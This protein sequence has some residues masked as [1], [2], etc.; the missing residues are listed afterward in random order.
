[1]MNWNDAET[2]FIKYFEFI[3]VC[4][5]SRSKKFLNLKFKMLKMQPYGTA[6]Q[7]HTL[8]SLP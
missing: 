8:V 7:W 6:I 1:M 5:K 2:I 4:S 3:V